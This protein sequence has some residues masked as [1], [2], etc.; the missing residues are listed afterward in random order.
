MILQMENNITQIQGGIT[1]DSIFADNKTHHASRKI[2]A[3][4]WV[5]DF[6]RGGKK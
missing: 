1:F 4:G 3:P 2:S 6:Y 5:F